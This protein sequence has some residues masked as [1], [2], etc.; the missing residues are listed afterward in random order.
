MYQMLE[1]FIDYYGYLDNAHKANNLVNSVSLEDNV[2]NY[3]SNLCHWYV[4]LM[5]ME[6]VV[7]EGDVLRLIPTLK[8]SLLFFFSHSRLSKYFVECLDFILKT[9]Y[10]LS[11]MQKMRVLEGV[12][13]NLRGGL[14]QNIECD[15]VQENSVRN[16]KDLIRALGANKTNEAISRCT[17]AADTVSDIC[18]KIDKSKGVKKPSS[19]HHTP[20]S[21]K[22]ELVIHLSLRAL[23]P[24]LKEKVVT[25]MVCQMLQLPHF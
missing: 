12:F 25:V 14:G 9:E 4:H 22:D 11:P 17:K 10:I 8:Y 6:D 13:V 2:Y 23:R 15:L 19:R 21:V 3:S 16:Q 18:S 20:K 7:R 24:F 1:S 5:N